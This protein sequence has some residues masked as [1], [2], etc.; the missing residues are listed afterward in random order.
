MAC[1]GTS[2]LGTHTMF[3]NIVDMG[4]YY[5]T[6]IEDIESAGGALMYGKMM[7]YKIILQIPIIGVIYLQPGIV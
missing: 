2:T 1:I 5:G 7:L 6:L 4:F 3:N